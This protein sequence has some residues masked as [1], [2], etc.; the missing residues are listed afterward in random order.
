[1]E[2]IIVMGL[3][4]AVIAAVY[5]EHTGKMSPKK[6]AAWGFCLGVIGLLVVVLSKPQVQAVPEQEG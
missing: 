1:M 3:I 5:A 2:L 4:F 6:A